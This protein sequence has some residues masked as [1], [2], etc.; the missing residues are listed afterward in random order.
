MYIL[1]C[2]SLTI[3]PGVNGIDAINIGI[4]P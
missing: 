1:G 2:V 4:P 3:Y